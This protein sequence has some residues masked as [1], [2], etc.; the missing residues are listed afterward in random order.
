MATL[1]RGVSSLSASSMLLWGVKWR[2]ARSS[3]AGGRAYLSLGPCMPRKPTVTRDI[4]Q[5]RNARIVLS[6]LA[7]AIVLLILIMLVI[8]LLGD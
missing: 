2:R 4:E 5:E 7:A 3:G 6:S 8:S 1:V